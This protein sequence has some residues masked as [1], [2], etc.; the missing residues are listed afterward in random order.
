MA[1]AHHDLCFGC[2]QTNLFGLHM[3]LEHTGAGSVAGRWFVKQDQQGPDP[4]R[5]HPGVLA[6]ALLEAVLLAGG[7]DLELR[8]AELRLEE[9]GGP[10]V[11]S[12][13]E[14][15]ATVGLDGASVV[16]RATASAGGSAVARLSCEGARRDGP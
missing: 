12:F 9:E 2:G 10:R 4:G 16:A 6:C 15:E 5:A 8:R 11:G 14:I 13:A 3:E 1:L 7:G